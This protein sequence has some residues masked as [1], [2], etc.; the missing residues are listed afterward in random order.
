M[1]IV[2]EGLQDLDDQILNWYAR[3]QRNLPWR[4]TCNPY[5]IWVSEIMLQQTQVKTVIPYYYRFLSRFPT[6]QALASASLDDVLK[7]WENMGYYARA[8][9]LHSAAVEIVERFGGKIPNTWEEL[10]GL[11]GVGSYT[12]GAILSIAFSQSVPAIDS[13][14]RRVLS[15]LYAID[16]PLEQSQTQRR[17]ADLTKR[18]LPKHNAGLFNQALMDLGANICTPQKPGCKS[19]PIWASCKAHQGQLQDA[20]P[21]TKKRP[22]IPHSHVTAAVI[23]DTHG[24]ILV[25]RRPNKGLLGGLWKF[26]GGLQASDETLGRSLRRTVREEV[27]IQI[28]VGKSITSV[29]HAYTHFRITLHAFQC[30]HETG[31]PKALGCPDWRWIELRQLEDLALSKADRKIIEAL[32][33]EAS[34]AAA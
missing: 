2:E 27:G 18:L 5:H 34:Q 26:P 13:N 24:R 7:A 25:V 12:A 29:N 1:S 8:R 10:I 20:L 22:P 31:K 6:V 28:R 30:T 21:V 14:V 32:T 17:I 33:S 19:C 11:P 4:K 23:R 16:Q 9:H 15:R 3:S